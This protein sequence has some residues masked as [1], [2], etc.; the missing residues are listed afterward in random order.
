MD[1]YSKLE[2]IFSDNN[3]LSDSKKLEEIDNLKKENDAKRKDLKSQ[4][5]TLEKLQAMK[6][7]SQEVQNWLKNLKSQLKEC[8]ND[9]DLLL[10]IKSNLNT[11]KSKKTKTSKK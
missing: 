1:V 6:I 2:N 7:N 3:N 8:L 5:I 4:I 9:E 10:K 11:N